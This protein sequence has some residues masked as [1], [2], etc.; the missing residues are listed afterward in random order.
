LKRVASELFVNNSDAITFEV[1]AN[2]SHGYNVEI[3][4]LAELLAPTP[5][6]LLDP[7]GLRFT[8]DN[9]VVGSDG[10]LLLYSKS[11][12]SIFRWDP[13]QQVYG[14]TI[15]LVGIADYMA[16]SSTTNTIYL[17]YHSGV[18][19]KI[20]LGS[21]EIHEE[22]FASLPQ[23]PLGLTTA[24]RYLFAVDASG[25]GLAHKIFDPNGTLVSSANLIE[26]S[27]E[28]IWSETNQKMY[29]FRDG[30]SPNDLYWEE[31]NANGVAY[32][33]LPPGGI[34]QR[35]DSPY[36][37]SSGI[38]HPIRVAPDG[39]VVVL[40]SGLI[41]DAQTLERLD[42]SVPEYLVDAAW[43]GDALFTVRDTGN[44]AIYQKWTG[45]SYSES[46]ELR[47]SDVPHALLAISDNRLLGITIG[48]NGVPSLVVLDENL[49]IVPRPVPVADAGSDQTVIAGRMGSLDGSR[50]LDPDATPS[51]ITYEW[52]LLEGPGN[53]AFSEPT[54]ARTNF[55]VDA[56]GN[57]LVQ[58][59]IRDGIHSVSDQGIVAASANRAPVAIAAMSSSPPVYVGRYAFLTAINSSDADRD[60]LTYQWRIIDSPAGSSPVLLNDNL[61]YLYFTTDKPGE[62][63]IELTVSDGLLSSRAI[64]VVPVLGLRPQDF[65]IAL[66]AESGGLPRVKVID[67]RDGSVTASFLAYNTNFRGGVRVAVGDLNRDGVSEI[68]VAPGP[69]ISTLVKV[70][71]IHGNE[72][73][74]YRTTAYAGYRSG[75]FVAVG[76]VN[77]D[78]R[79]DIV[80]T[81]DAGPSV[82]VKVFKNRVGIVSDNPDPISN[83]PVRSFLA[84]G[85][86]FKG[87]GTV[88][89]GDF[90][91]NGKAEIVVGNGPGMGPHVRVFNLTQFDTRGL[92]PFYLELRPFK[93]T[94]RGGVFVAVG[95]LRGTE[96]PEIIVGNGLGGRGRVEMYHSNGNRL[97]S[98]TAYNSSE[99]RNAPVHV[100]AKNVRANHRLEVVTAQGRPDSSHR[101][102]AFTDLAVLVDDVLEDD[103]DFRFGFFIA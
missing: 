26:F 94:D 59:T 82:E 13:A 74:D 31:I 103:E 66:G 86:S 20:D 32:P 92:A 71:D 6:Q 64:V 90:T 88:A 12:Q 29:F 100:A 5:G 18:I 65:V 53:I 83:N 87:G 69:G 102:K 75:V 56:A 30:L 35:R 91:G 34:G 72:L 70:F 40:G 76:D 97:Q 43:L 44:G 36:H 93:S 84:F 2:S 85:Q 14:D 28:Y 63:R 1:N 101:M 23:R 25:S 9:V 45:A 78:G 73:T 4:P 79:D 8:P 62:Y 81:P 55:V 27:F 67:A 16:Y 39:S 89:V 11:H 42:V 48:D 15:P 7:V 19:R 54:A 60:P 3:V 80:T 98:V 61:N 22:F 95:D 10:Q 50:S 33:S 49:S 38:N 41:H 52:T 57:Y 21:A 24:G 96:R 99:G 46:G 68:I 51:P 37:E 58:L 77:G 17:A 47:Q